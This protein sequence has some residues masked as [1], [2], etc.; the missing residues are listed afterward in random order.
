[1]GAHT[2]RHSLLPHPLTASGGIVAEASGP[3]SSNS[4]MS[5][6]AKSPAHLVPLVSWVQSCAPN[7]PES[8]P[9]RDLPSQRSAQL[10]SAQRC[11]PAPRAEVH[12]L[13]TAH[14]AA[15]RTTN[16]CNRD[17]WAE[18]LGSRLILTAA[19][20]DPRHPSPSPALRGTHCP[21]SR[22]SQLSQFSLLPVRCPRFDFCRSP[23]SLEPSSSR[24]RALCLSHR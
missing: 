12:L 21:L 4:P 2:Q 9:T 3:P 16:I 6:C 10:A 24:S 11:L 13:A 1:M 7:P 17:C 8:V 19:P 20:H 22:L 14:R 18:L 23:S 15:R 5:Q